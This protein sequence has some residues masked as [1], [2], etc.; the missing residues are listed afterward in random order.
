MNLN[1]LRTML[2]SSRPYPCNT[3]PFG[4]FAEQPT[5]LKAMFIPTHKPFPKGIKAIG[6]SFLKKLRL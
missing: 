6:N 3:K 2:L 1:I 5:K 4:C